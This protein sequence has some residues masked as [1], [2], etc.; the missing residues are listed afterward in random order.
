MTPPKPTL[1]VIGGPTASGKTKLA[2]QMAKRLSCP[3]I[4]FDSRQ[5]YREMHIG[6]ARPLPEHWE[7]VTHYFLGH[8][9]IH[10]PWDA[11][12]FAREATLLIE[13]LEEKHQNLV[14][15][16]GSGFYAE[17][18]LYGLD[19]LPGAQPAYRET[20]MREWRAGKADALVNRLRQVDPVL[21]QRIDVKNPVRVIRAL[22]VFDS[23]GI[24][25]SELQGKRQP[26]ANPVQWLVLTPDRDELWENIAKRTRQMI[27][28]GL[29]EEA[30]QLFQ[31]KHSLALQTV[32]YA[33][34]F[35]AWNGKFAEE[36][37]EN[38][39]IIHTR[40]YAKRQ[41]TW[42]RRYQAQRGNE[43]TLW[44]WFLDQRVV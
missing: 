16:G 19:K 5:F 28:D 32:G 29:R 14:L 27:A 36:E 44:S 10:E 41:D 40:Q 34:W 39:I 43:T 1:W 31:H 4:S 35:D 38:K 3:V 25:M 8:A 17:A 7:G 42:F 18:L 13:K 37:V 30:C 20:H 11:E 33:E 2:I 21:A 15:V 6:T 9:S 23:T 22:E 24:P 12:R 26:I